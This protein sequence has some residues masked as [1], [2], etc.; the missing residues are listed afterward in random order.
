MRAR[1]LQAR[2]ARL[3][4]RYARSGALA[5][6]P[7]GV[8]KQAKPGDPNLLAGEDYLGQNNYTKAAEAVDCPFP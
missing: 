2:R 8:I 3:L 4:G 6:P 1:V 7:T 5:S